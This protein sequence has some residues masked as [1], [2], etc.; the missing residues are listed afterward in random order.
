M[1]SNTC[2]ISVISPVYRGAGMVSELVERIRKAMGTI[3]ANVATNASSP[4]HSQTLTP[5]LG[6]WAPS[7]AVI[8][9]IAAK[10]MRI[11]LPPPFPLGR[12]Q[13]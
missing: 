10:V 4:P 9:V 2:H 12:S 1:S 5:P 11:T 13:G 7:P 3:A 8:M 6:T